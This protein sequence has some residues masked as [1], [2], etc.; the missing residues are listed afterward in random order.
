[1]AVGRG[2]TPPHPA[3]NM[4]VIMD[5][6]NT[7][8]HGPEDVKLVQEAAAVAVSWVLGGEL[9]NEQSLLLEIGYHTGGHE[10]VGIAGWVHDWQRALRGVLDGATDNEESRQRVAAATDTALREMLLYLHHVVEM[11]WFF[12]SQDW[13][14]YHEVLRRIITA[15]GPEAREATGPADTAS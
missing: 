3:P 4:I 6:T 8:G 9:T 11:D 13:P 5:G 10:M 1:M 14:G 12:R 7:Y 15:G 2:G